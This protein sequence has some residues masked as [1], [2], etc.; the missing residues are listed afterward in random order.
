MNLE[1]QQSKEWIQSEIAES[2][3]VKQ[4]FS[5]SLIQ[6]IAELAAKISEA[7]SKGGKVIFFGNGGSA[8]DALHL[9]AELVGRFESERRPLPAL[10]LVAN[11]AALS[12]IANDY[13]YEAV[14]ERQILAF[15]GPDDVVIGIST[16]GSSKNVVRGMVAAGTKQAFRVALTGEKAGGVSKNAELVLAVPS[17]RTARIQEA[18][19]MMGHIVCGLVEKS[20]KKELSE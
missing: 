17:S 14:F 4:S 10:A 5:E 12:A 13:G 11:P 8:T 7:Y 15:A 20:L 6:A 3:S 19:I 18:H 9:A 1:K 2:I 16:S